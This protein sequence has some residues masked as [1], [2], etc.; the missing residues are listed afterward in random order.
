M[1]LPNMN[2]YPGP[3]SVIVLDNC[4][5]HKSEAVHEAVEASGKFSKFSYCIVY[6]PYILIGA[7][8]SSFYDRI[9]PTSTRSKRALAAVRNFK[10][11]FP[12]FINVI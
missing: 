7:V 5:T 4:S 1:Q 11:A 12:T 6:C 10:Y 8:C 2:P 9:H 3:N